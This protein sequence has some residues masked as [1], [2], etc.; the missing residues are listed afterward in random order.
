MYMSDEDG[1][2]VLE[3]ED[4]APETIEKLLGAIDDAEEVFRMDIDSPRE[5]E[6]SKVEYRDK[7]ILDYSGGA[8]AMAG[9]LAEAPATVLKLEYESPAVINGQKTYQRIVFEADR[10]GETVYELTMR[11]MSDAGMD[12]QAEYDGAFDSMLISSI[13]ERKEG[14]GGNFNEFYKNGEIGANA[15]DIEKLQKG[16]II[17]WRYAEESDGT[18]GGCPDFAMIKMMLQQYTGGGAY[19]SFHKQGATLAPFATQLQYS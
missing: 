6:I 18:C 2:L 15:V 16:D 13:N 11:K 14:D 5:I 3:Y 9:R 10:P 7:A 17:E 8:A 1:Q 4:G 12:V 19:S